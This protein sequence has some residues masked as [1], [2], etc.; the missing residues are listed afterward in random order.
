MARRSSRAAH[1]SGAR[2]MRAARG[3]CKRRNEGEH[4]DHLRWTLDPAD[5]ED[6]AESRIRSDSARDLP[7][8]SSLAR[9]SVP[10]PLRAGKRVR[11][12]VRVRVRM[13]VHSY[14]QMCAALI[15]GAV[16]REIG[17]CQ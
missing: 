14:G 5:A 17:A 1:A 2:L 12:R 13:R 7:S 9:A 16:L 4:P 15:V 3:S 6:R 10:T 8:A 11:V